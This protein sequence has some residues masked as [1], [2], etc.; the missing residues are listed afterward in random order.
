M[1]NIKL[2]SRDY[3]ISLSAEVQ[4]L[5]PPISLAP[6]PPRGQGGGGWAEALDLQIKI[7]LAKVGFSLEDVK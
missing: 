2:K 4:V 3:S 1:F 7:Q 5:D 6:K